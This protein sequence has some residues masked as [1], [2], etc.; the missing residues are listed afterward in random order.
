MRVNTINHE[1]RA[2]EDACAHSREDGE[3]HLH[4]PFI[5]E[6]VCD[7]DFEGIE[8]VVCDAEGGAVDGLH[9]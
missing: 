7:F 8:R 2:K 3:K 9:D 6:V 5:G 4:R 1:L